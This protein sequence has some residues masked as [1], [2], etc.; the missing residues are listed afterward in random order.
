M[1]LF[2]MTIITLVFAAIGFLS[3]SNRGN[4]MVALLVLFVLMGSTAGYT[5][6]QTYKMFKGK[7]WQLCTT[8]TAV[9]FPGITFGTFFLLN[10]FAWG[11][12]SDAAVPFGSMLLVV[13]LWFCISVPLVFCGA[14]LGYRYA[15]EYVS[16][17]AH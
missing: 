7:R 15:C 13:I 2:A 17:I 16:T 11:A 14:W 3:P 5:S 9:L 12:G 8:M 10:L 1:Q 4:L 6:A